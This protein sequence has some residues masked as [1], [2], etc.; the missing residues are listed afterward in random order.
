[1]PALAPI[2]KRIDHV[3]VR[4]DDPGP[5][6]ELLSGPLGL[7]VSWPMQNRG[8]YA[9]GGISFGNACLE[10]ARLGR[11]RSRGAGSARLFGLALEPHPLSGCLHELS[12]RGIPHSLPVPFRSE[13][14]DGIRGLCWTNVV[15][16]G[17]TG[18]SH[19]RL[20]RRHWGATNSLPRRALD[21]LARVMA[22]GHWARLATSA[23]GRHMVYMC[24]YG[25]ARLAN[26]G[27]FEAD[28]RGALRLLGLAEVVLGATNL[29][30]ARRRWQ[31]LL[32]P[33]LPEDR[34]FWRPGGGAGLRIVPHDE[35][36]MLG[37][38]LQTANLA[39]AEG[40]LRDH[41]MLGSVAAHQVTIDPA[42]TYGLDVRL[43][44]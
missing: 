39:A 37:L 31:N 35:D 38:V 28:G 15:L 29:E 32:A 16:G 1:M 33:L 24:E 34:G 18:E 7:P 14:P 21:P 11:S 26:Q 3:V 10:V 42:A 43:V 44:E 6:F 2:V 17:L 20:L 36:T 4:V 25:D 9:S 19:S 27:G 23:T 5:L 12:A 13:G 41:G 30:R 8:W 22:L 40:W